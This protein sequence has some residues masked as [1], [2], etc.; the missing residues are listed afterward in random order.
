MVREGAL[1]LTVGL[2]WG[3]GAWGNKMAAGG[4]KSHFDVDGTSG[5][6]KTRDNHSA[7]PSSKLMYEL[8]AMGDERV[9]WETAGLPSLSF[10]GGRG[11]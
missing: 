11:E 1:A 3:S 10:G 4:A 5:G 7:N 9:G 2:A 8:A 6:R